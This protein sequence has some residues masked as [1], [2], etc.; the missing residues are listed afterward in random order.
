MT[1]LESIIE[2]MVERAYAAAEK[3]VEKIKAD[4]ITLGDLF[5]HA[6]QVEFTWEDTEAGDWIPWMCDDEDCPMNWHKKGYS[7]NMGR[8]QDGRRWI[9]RRSVDEDSDWDTVGYWEEGEDP[10]HLKTILFEIQHEHTEYFLN[11]TR[12]WL[13]C[14]ETN[15]DEL[16]EVWPPKPVPV[17]KYLEYAEDNIRF[18]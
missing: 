14:A 11:W 7:L 2:S 1:E 6:P 13:F 3:S 17:E 9:E 4:P 10:D 5:E 16:K 8:K 15:T 18:I 12:Y